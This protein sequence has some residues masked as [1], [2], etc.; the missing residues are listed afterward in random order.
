MKGRIQ[1]VRS[2]AV[3][4]RIILFVLGIWLML[5]PFYFRYG[6]VQSHTAEAI[7]GWFTMIFS[8]Y[9]IGHPSF[10]AWISWINFVIGAWL[11]ASPFMFKYSGLHG[12]T[13]NDIAIGVAMIVLAVISYAGSRSQTAAQH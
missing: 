2:W 5:G 1:L 8:V 10:S 4:V 12:P 6:N 7:A 11:I 3:A 9:R 13:I